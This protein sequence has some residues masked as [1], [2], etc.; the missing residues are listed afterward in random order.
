MKLRSIVWVLVYMAAG[1]VAFWAPDVALQASRAYEFSGR[2]AAILTLLLPWTLLTCYGILLWLRGSQSNEP[3][4]SIFMLIGVWLLSSL[5]MMIGASFSGGGFAMP[6]AEVWIVIALGL[7][8][9]YT[10]IMAT[11]DGS[12]LGLLLAT[13]LMILMHLRF[14][15]N[16]WVLP[17]RIRK[18]A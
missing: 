16:R 4:I 13:A 14:E 3:S 5:S 1:G 8:P 17:V 12:L 18:P 15:R 10:F 9:P 11:Y 2:D 7:L 6:G